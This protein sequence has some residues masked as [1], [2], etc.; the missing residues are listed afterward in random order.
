M[1][2]NT[3]LPGTGESIADEDIS[4]VKYQRMKLIDATVGSTTP[5]G[6]TAN[7]LKVA[8]LDGVKVYFDGTNVVVSKADLWP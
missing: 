8:D 5:V 1:A 6:T 2:D 4:G 3:T 7:P